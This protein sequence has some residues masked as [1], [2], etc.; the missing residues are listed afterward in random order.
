MKDCYPSDGTGAGCGTERCYALLFYSLSTIYM[1]HEVNDTIGELLV[2]YE[3]GELDQIA[4]LDLF[5]RLIDDGSVWKLQGHYGRTAIQLIRA[6]ECLLGPV[7][8]HDYYGNYVPSR[9]EVTSET[10]GSV[11]YAKNTN[12]RE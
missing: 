1:T 7:G 12:S 11:E 10:P 9:Y 6:G 8:H 2:A 4:S 5:Q 3:A